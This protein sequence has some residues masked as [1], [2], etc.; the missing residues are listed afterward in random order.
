MNNQ[1]NGTMFE[2]KL[3]S[4]LKKEGIKAFLLA[5]PESADLIVLNGTHR[6]IECKTT[7]TA[8][9]TVKNKSQHERLISFAKDGIS[10]YYAI[11]F[12]LKHKSTIR[13]FHILTSDYPYDVR[14]G[15][16]LEEFVYHLKVGHYK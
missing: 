16:S 15:Y 4:L 8:L 7:H 3:K 13:F 5:I 14:G 2:S 9:W 11:R 6:L 1:Q 10:V 12:T